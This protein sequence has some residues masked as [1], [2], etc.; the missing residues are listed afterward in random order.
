MGKGNE[1]NGGSESSPDLS[2]GFCPLW[3]GAAPSLTSYH[4]HRHDELGAT[5]LAIYVS[6]FTLGVILPPVELLRTTMR[7]LGHVSPL[8]IK[9]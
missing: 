5:E 7:A 4:S 2:F 6:C 1:T 8:V 3:T 9:D